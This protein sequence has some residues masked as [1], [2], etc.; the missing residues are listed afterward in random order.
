MQ[1][2]PT[3]RWVEVRWQVPR[4]QC[5]LVASSFSSS[6]TLVFLAATRDL[7]QDKDR[8][9]ICC[10]DQRHSAS[11]ETVLPRVVM[12]LAAG[13]RLLGG[14]YLYAMCSCQYNVVLDGALVEI[15][16]DVGGDVEV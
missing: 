14:M 16:V 13:D 8:S 11:G 5:Y 7:L 10:F 9:P 6:D 15:P 2:Q 4:T 3:P 12:P 1:D